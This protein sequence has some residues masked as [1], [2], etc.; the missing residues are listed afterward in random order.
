[1]S[2][3]ENKPRK[4]AFALARIKEIGVVNLMDEDM[5]PRARRP[6]SGPARIDKPET[7]ILEV[8]EWTFQLQ[9]NVEKLAHLCDNDATRVKYLLREQMVWRQTHPSYRKRYRLARGVQTSD[10]TRA[11][12]SLRTSTEVGI[13]GKASSHGA[14]TPVEDKNKKEE[15]AEATSPRVTV[16]V[17]EGRASP[18]VYIKQEEDDEEGPC[19][20]KPRLDAPMPDEEKPTLPESTQQPTFKGKAMLAFPDLGSN[21]PG[22]GTTLA[23]AADSP[24]GGGQFLID[25]LSQCLERLRKINEVLGDDKEGGKSEEATFSAHLIAS[26]K[27]RQATRKLHTKGK[28]DFEQACLEIRTLDNQIRKTQLANEQV[29]AAMWCA[30]IS[31][32]LEEYAGLVLEEHLKHRFTSVLPLSVIENTAHS[33]DA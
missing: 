22:G 12:E 9:I 1:M 28:E 20:K 4:I 16:K 18:E 26:T 13:L 31:A 10:T 27:L 21:A 11:L 15:E 23:R 7:R 25:M 29:E 32:H 17:E 24:D 8:D 33:Q 14:S 3:N 5:R 2:E 19:K 6:G 30:A